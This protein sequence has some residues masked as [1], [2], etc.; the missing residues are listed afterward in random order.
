MRLAEPLPL[1][2]GRTLPVEV[3]F[4]TYGTLSPARDNAVLVL[5]GL[6][7][8]HHAAGP[9]RADGG[10]PGW[11][12][13]AI[14]PGKALDTDALCVVCPNVIGGAASTGPSSLDPATGK[15]YALTFP[16]VTVADMVAAQIK[17]ADALQIARFH[18]V[19]GGCF[20]GF[21]VLEWLA[22]A[23]DRVDRAVVISATAKTSAH[24]TALWAVLRAAIMSDP[25][26]KD[27]Q[28]GT[29]QPAS[30]IGLLAMTGALFWMSRETLENR[31][32]TRT[33]DGKA[34]RYTLD[35]DFTVEDFLDRVRQN[36]ASGHL[37]ANSLIYLTRAIDY[38]DMARDHGSLRTAFEGV[39]APVLL[40]SYASDWRY[41]AEEMAEIAAAMPDGTVQHEVLESPLGHGAFIYE[42]QTL[43]PLLKAFV[44]APVTPR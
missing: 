31:F 34:P 16:V 15:A 35:T 19:I 4:N 27:G 24:N 8:D 30:G 36:A 25:A 28:Y 13:A 5:H 33:V 43:A 42:F 39:R 20:G 29:E 6:T 22:Q 38:F 32:G 3:V 1:T 17:L 37:D 14:G 2:C 7:G 44:E 41:P 12:D 40:V 9:P 23:P 18:T 21:Q 26:F 10:K 11:W